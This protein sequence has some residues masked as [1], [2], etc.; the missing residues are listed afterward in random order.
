M[1]YQL[2]IPKIV[3]KRSRK[4]KPIEQFECRAYKDNNRLWVLHCFKE[5]IFRRSKIVGLET[6]Q[7]IIT[8][9]KPYKGASCF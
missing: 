9:K 4:E 3:L 8:T 7:F 6:K 5:Y 1:I 2:L